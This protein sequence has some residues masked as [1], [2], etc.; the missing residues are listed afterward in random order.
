MHLQNLYSVGVYTCMHAY[1]TKL[2]LIYTLHLCHGLYSRQDFYF[3]LQLSL[4]IAVYI[5]IPSPDSKPWHALFICQC[6]LIWHKDN[7]I[8]LLHAII[9]K[10]LAITESN[11]IS[12]NQ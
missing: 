5:Y 10:R 11:F 3:L 4:Q 12:H 2:Y 7:D 8:A 9:I 6:A 1:S